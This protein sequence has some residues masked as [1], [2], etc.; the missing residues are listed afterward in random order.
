MLTRI[1]REKMHVKW[2]NI[3]MKDKQNDSIAGML[4]EICDN[5][6]NNFCKY[7]ETADENA[8]CDFV[9]EG[10]RCPLYILV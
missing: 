7:N 10:N 8:E 9:R 3:G 2:G 1:K 6:C 4:E 5:F